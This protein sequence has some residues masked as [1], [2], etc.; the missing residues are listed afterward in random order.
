MELCDDP[1]PAQLPPPLAMHPSD[2]APEMLLCIA[3]F[4]T[5]REVVSVGL[6]ASGLREVGESHA[7]MWRAL[8]R[9]AL[10]EHPFLRNADNDELVARAAAGAGGVSGGWRALFHARFC[11]ACARFR[12]ARLRAAQFELARLADRSPTSCRRAQMP[13]RDDSP[14][15][16]MEAAGHVWDAMTLVLDLR[17][18]L[19]SAEQ[20]A[21]ADA[22]EGRCAAASGAPGGDSARL[23]AL[24]PVLRDHARVRARQCCT[25]S[26]GDSDG[27][28]VHQTLDKEDDE[29]VVA[30]R[31]DAKEDAGEG[32]AGEEACAELAALRKQNKKLAAVLAHERSALRQVER[33]ARAAGMELGGIAT[34]CDL[35]YSTCDDATVSGHAVTE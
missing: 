19:G 23:R 24:L 16:C 17:P 6:L 33:A 9:A 32:D 8:C 25:T 18:L 3:G 20:A 29:E 12:G 4:L 1:S 31:D 28:P 15:E 10:R 5:L 14:A 13:F 21:V 7:S 30:C 11:P 22:V 35:P 26:R 34:L 2:L 27:A